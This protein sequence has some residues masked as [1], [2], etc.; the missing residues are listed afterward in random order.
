MRQLLMKTP[1]AKTVGA[2][3]SLLGELRPSFWHLNYPPSPNFPPMRLWVTLLIDWR[4]HLACL[5]RN[6]M[7]LPDNHIYLLQ[8]QE[9]RDISLILFLLRCPKAK[10]LLVLIMASVYLLNNRWPS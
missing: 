3:L 10:T 8:Q 1:K 6:R 7:I 4:Q 9:I 5:A 2:K